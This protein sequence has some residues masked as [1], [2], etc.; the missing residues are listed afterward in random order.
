MMMGSMNE[1]KKS[2]VATEQSTYN[3]LINLAKK[4]AGRK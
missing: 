3:D 1:N 2:N 4:L